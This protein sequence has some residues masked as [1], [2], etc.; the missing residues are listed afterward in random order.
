MHL[1]KP[2]QSGNPAGKPLGARGKLSQR[3]YAAWAKAWALKGYETILW[4]AENDPATFLRVAASLLPRDVRLEA[5]LKDLRIVSFVGAAV[6]ECTDSEGEMV[7]IPE[8]VPD[9]PEYG[10]ES[11]A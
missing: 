4:A 7:E 2:G 6:Q 11:G 1:W 5:T 10:P 8:L 9:E 3:V